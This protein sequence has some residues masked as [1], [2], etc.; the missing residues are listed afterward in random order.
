[1]LVLTVWAFTMLAGLPVSLMRAATMISIFAIFSLG[2]RPHMS[3]NLLCLTAILFLLWNPRVLYDVGF[4]LSFSAVMA[5]LTL[6]P[7]MMGLPDYGSKPKVT[8][9]TS[10]LVSFL[11]VSLAAQIGVAPLIA[12]YFGR[13][14][15]YFL[16]TNLVVLPAAY[17][18]LC[19]SLL[20]LIVPSAAVAVVWIVELLNWLLVLISQLPKSSIEGLHPSILQIVLYYVIVAAVCGIIKVLNNRWFIQSE[21]EVGRKGLPF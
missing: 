17:L 1:M 8:G 21:T 11:T 15:I 14:S 4:Q 2:N 13:F 7:F 5:I 16:L 18:I 19:G 20:M 3:V 9:I 6:I 10:V 12:Y